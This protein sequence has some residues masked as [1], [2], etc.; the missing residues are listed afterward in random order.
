MVEFTVR[1]LSL[2]LFHCAPYVIGTFR[3]GPA[4][5]VGAGSHYID[6][7]R[8]AVVEIPGFGALDLHSFWADMSLRFVFYARPPP[9]KCYFFF[10]RQDAHNLGRS[11]SFQSNEVPF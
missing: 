11:L 1:K 7:E 2:H 5:G 4:R 3:G 10:V 9:V 8:W 6:F